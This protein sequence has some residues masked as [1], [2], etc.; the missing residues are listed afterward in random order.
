MT[1]QSTTKASP[2]YAYCSTKRNPK[3]PQA[4]VIS[5]SDIEHFRM[6]GYATIDGSKC[7]AW[8]DKRDRKYYFQVA[9][10]R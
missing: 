1:T 9:L 5:E 7:R 8:V 2:G 6:V 10:G 4:V 3:E